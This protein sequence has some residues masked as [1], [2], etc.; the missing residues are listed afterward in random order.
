MGFERAP[1]GAG[2]EEALEWARRCPW[3]LRSD[4]CRQAW[5]QFY[6]DDFD[7][8]EIVPDTEVPALYGT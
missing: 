6:L 1:E 2:H 5:V 3:P 4:T 7:A 8:P